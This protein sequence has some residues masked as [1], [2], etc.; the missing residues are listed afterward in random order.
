[1]ENLEEET[2]VGGE[3]DDGCVTIEFDVTDIVREFLEKKERDRN[4]ANV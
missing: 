1:M 2:T 4:A 3:D